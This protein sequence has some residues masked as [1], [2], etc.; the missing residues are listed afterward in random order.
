MKL[1]LQAGYGMMGLAVELSEIW[2]GATTIL[3][4]RD[5]DQQQL[6]SFAGK[7]LAGAGNRILI[8]PQLY[9]PRAD[10]HKLCAH[11][12]W[13]KNFETGPFFGSHA[14]GKLVAALKDLNINARTDE[15]LVPGLLAS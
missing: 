14:V 9:S 13:P 15:F 10:H 4:P 7:L 1:C 8:D 12:Y 5:S 3:S 11:E 2:K 6:Y